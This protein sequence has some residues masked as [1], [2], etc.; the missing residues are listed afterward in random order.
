MEQ[1]AADREK[2]EV[3]EDSVA[4]A[5]PRRPDQRAHVCARSAGSARRM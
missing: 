5:D 4:W 1:V 3:A 2:A